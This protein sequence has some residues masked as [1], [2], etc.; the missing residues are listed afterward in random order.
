MKA[1]LIAFAFTQVVEVPIYLRAGAGWR[2]AILA[3]TFTHPVVWFGFPALRVL[4][5][6]YWGTV[7][8]VECFAIGAE[9][10]WLTTRGVRRALLWSLVANGASVALGLLSRAVLGWP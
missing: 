2:A 10:L 3:S 6:G 9:A 8:L 7:L 5:L 1:W 4:G